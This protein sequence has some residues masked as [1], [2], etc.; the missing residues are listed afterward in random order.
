MNQQWLHKIMCYQTENM[1]DYRIVSWITEFIMKFVSFHVVFHLF[2]SSFPCDLY[3]QYTKSVP[4]II[5][6]KFMNVVL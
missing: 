4:C 1:Q 2:I 3:Q 6:M 5:R